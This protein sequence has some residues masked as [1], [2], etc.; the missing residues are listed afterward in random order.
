MKTLFP[1]MDKE[2]AEG[3]LADRRQCRQGARAWISRHKGYEKFI[4]KKLT[5]DGPT[6]DF[7]MMRIISELTSTGDWRDNR[8]LDCSL[9]VH[10][11]CWAMWVLGVLNRKEFPNHPSGEKCFIYSLRKC[12]IPLKN[13]PGLK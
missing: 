4:I 1:E 6:A 5:D 13:P 2:I 3:R 10:T 12:F 7:T 11:T 8:G 9:N